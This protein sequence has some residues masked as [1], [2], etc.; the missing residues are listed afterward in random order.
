MTK[1]TVTPP[2]LNNLTPTPE[3][4]TMKVLEEVGELMQMIGKHSGLSGEKPTMSDEVRI[5]RT[6]FEALDVAQSAVTMAN[7]LCELHGLELETFVVSH[8]DKLR[9]KGYLR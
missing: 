1:N 8:E 3:S 9:K 4:C 5:R 6:I 7:V 2:I